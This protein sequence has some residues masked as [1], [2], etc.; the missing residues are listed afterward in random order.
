MVEQCAW[1]LIRSGL[2][3]THGIASAKSPLPKYLRPTHPT[4]AVNRQLTF[5]V[6]LWVSTVMYEFDDSLK[7]G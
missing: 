4:N 7:P 1:L 6:M 2:Y 5:L 3:G